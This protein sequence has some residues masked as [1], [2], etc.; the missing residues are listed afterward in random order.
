[1]LGDYIIDF[2]SNPQF[3]GMSSGNVILVSYTFQCVAIIIII[4]FTIVLNISVIIHISQCSIKNKMNSY[5]LTKHLC[6]V[7]LLGG[8]LIL[9]FPFIATLTGIYIPKT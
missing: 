2:I 1:M 7:D 5:I 6:I 3:L 9:P 8:V 4:F